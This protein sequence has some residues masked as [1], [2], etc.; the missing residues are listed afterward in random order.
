[1]TWGFA[2]DTDVPVA[3]GGIHVGTSALV[4]MSTWVVSFWFKVLHPVRRCGIDRALD[5]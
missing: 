2:L 3:A 1:V 4:P 5:P